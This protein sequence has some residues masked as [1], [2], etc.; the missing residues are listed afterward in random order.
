M[1]A[2]FLF[3]SNQTSFRIESTSLG[4]RSSIAVWASKR[5]GCLILT[6]TRG[7]RRILNNE[8]EITRLLQKVN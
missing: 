5:D 3:I 1:S 2:I 6:Q 4:K 8:G 7:Y